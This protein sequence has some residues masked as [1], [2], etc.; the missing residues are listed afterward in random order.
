MRALLLMSILVATVAIPIRAA[1]DADP[2]R[3][4]RRAVRSMV[5]FSVLYA[6]A[7]AYVYGRLP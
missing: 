2:R 3:G 1:R 7:C 6:L 4:L 5:V